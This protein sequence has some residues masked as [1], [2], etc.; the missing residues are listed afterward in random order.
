M[1]GRGRRG[2]AIATA[3]L[4]LASCATDQVN[5]LGKAVPDDAS[6]FGFPSGSEMK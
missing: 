5:P 3:C 4:V 2:L 1:G 6:I